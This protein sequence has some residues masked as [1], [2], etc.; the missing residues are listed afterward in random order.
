MTVFL[1]LSMRML[2]GKN[3]VTPFRVRLRLSRPVRIVTTD[4]TKFSLRN[5]MSLLMIAL[6]GLSP[7]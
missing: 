3:C 6:L 2:F 5:L 7:S 1:I 4:S